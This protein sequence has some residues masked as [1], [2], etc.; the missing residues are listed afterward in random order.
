MCM[1]S[2]SSLIVVSSQLAPSASDPIPLIKPVWLVYRCIKTCIAVPCYVTREPSC[3]FPTPFPFPPYYSS[4]RSHQSFQYPT[5]AP[6]KL[7][8]TQLISNHF[9]TLKI[10]TVDPI[11]SLYPST[12]G[13]LALCSQKPATWPLANS[14]VRSTKGD[15]R[16]RASEGMSFA[17]VVS[18]IEV[19]KERIIYTRRES[20]LSRSRARK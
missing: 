4:A 2:R 19:E 11:A 5:T 14:V 6:M 18:S 8:P 3:R 12:K 10:S 13:T 15:S 17:A 16:C 20:A 1:S 9:K 7:I